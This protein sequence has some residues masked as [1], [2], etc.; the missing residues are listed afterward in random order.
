[1]ILYSFYTPCSLGEYKLFIGERG[2]KNEMGGT[3]SRRSLPF[4]T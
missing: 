1:L 3:D 4:L 2:I